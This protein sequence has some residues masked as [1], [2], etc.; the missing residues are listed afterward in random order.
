[1]GR[2]VNGVT[3]QYLV[4]I[5]NPTGYAQ[6]VDELIGG[7]V[8]RSY[9]FG[10]NLISQRQLIAGQWQ[11]NFYGYD[12]QG[13]VRLLTDFG[14]A[15]TDTYE[16]DAFGNLIAQTG[17]TPNEHLYVGEHFDANVGFYYLRAR[18]LNPDSGRFLTLDSFEGMV[19]DPVSLHK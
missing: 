15:I 5:N 11:V 6:V 3:T 7:Q 17:N 14:H 2:T 18:Y 9:T 10:H 13:N 16:F 4:D 8:T 1:M 12:G 19:F